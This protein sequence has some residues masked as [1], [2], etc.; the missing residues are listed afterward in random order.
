MTALLARLIQVIPS[1]GRGDRAWALLDG[2]GNVVHQSGGLDVAKGV[3]PVL[4]IGLGEVLPHWQVALY[5][6][7]PLVAGGGG[8]IRLASVL[9]VIAL[10][11]SILAGG[12][13][14][15]WESGRRAREAR[16]KTSFVA[17]VS[18]EL[19]TPL[20]TLRLY[21]E[22]L[23]EGRIK[24]E[25]KQ[26]QY[27][28]VMIAECARLGRLVNNML[29]FSRLEQNRRVYTVEPLE[30]TAWLDVFLEPQRIRFREA[31]LS[32]TVKPPASPL[33]VSVDHDAL[34]QAVLN[35]LDNTIKYAASGNVVEMQAEC[36]GTVVHLD[37]LDRGPGVPEEL[38]EKVF[39]DFFRLDAS[40]TARV[41]G[42]GLGLSLARRLLR[43]IGG[44]VVCLPREGGGAC[45]RIIMRVA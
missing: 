14:L 16:Q 42:S 32:L 34:E 22:L 29:D 13:L 44:D 12:G 8:S 43:E 41:P 23:R 31:G 17:N 25:D 11:I 24:G 39:E 10:L 21:A 40:L 45:F 30:L 6:G 1:E 5:S 38:R 4:A 2:A 15:L 36:Q 19:K 20:T 27:L 37:V 18:H 33:T 9:L 28:D 7:A 26:R 35:L 3:K